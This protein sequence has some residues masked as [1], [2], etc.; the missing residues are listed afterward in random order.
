MF[1]G[2]ALDIIRIYE[3][4]ITSEKERQKELKRLTQSNKIVMK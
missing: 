2:L 3:D 1:M 4:N